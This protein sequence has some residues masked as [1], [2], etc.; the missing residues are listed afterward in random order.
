MRSI[1]AISFVAL[2]AAAC[3]PVPAPGLGNNDTTIEDTG[4]TSSDTEWIPGGV[5]DPTEDTGDTSE[6]DQDPLVDN[7]GD[8]VHSDADCDDSDPDIHPYATEVCDGIDNNCNEEIDEDLGTNWY[9]DVDGDGFG[10]MTAE[11]VEACDETVE[12]YVADNTDCDDLAWT[13]NPDAPEVCDGYDNDCDGETDEDCDEDTEPVEDPEDTDV[14]DDTGMLEDTGEAE[15]TGDFEEVD[16]GDIEDETGDTEEEVDTAETEEDTGD[17]GDL[18]IASTE[19]TGD[20]ASDV[21]E[22][23]L[24]RVTFTSAHDLELNVEIEDDE[25]DLDGY[26]T[27]S[28]SAEA[29]TSVELSLPEIDPDLVWALLFNVTIDGSDWLCMG[30][31]GSGTASLDSDATIEIEIGGE[32]YGTSDVS[33]WSVDGSSSSA[34]CAAEFIRP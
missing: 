13:F 22:G 27:N 2:I 3:A 18:E 31:V 8:G 25:A 20:T 23:I 32:V 24:L 6:P 12:G 7:D 5:I 15:D 21:S 30:H 19:D 34:G 11:P 17:T 1:L 26:W 9:P 28:V 29:A 33:T 4:D 14:P 10:D 16:T